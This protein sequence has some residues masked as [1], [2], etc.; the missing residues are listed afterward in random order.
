MHSQ[1]SLSQIGGS[2]SEININTEEMTDIFIYL[3]NIINELEGCAIKEIE[4]LKDTNFYREGRAINAIN[5]YANA[6]EKI[7]ELCVHYQRAQSLV[8]DIL[9]KM[10]EKDEE[11]AR[12]ITKRLDMI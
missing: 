12:H 8:M 5:E 3:E 11:I 7:V 2:T 10:A 6:N 4:K 1:H 9:V